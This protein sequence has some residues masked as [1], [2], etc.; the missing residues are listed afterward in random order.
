MFGG[1]PFRVIISI[2][3]H[4][5]ADAFRISQNIECDHLFTGLD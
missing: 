1:S 4:I 5:P 3:Q 2:T